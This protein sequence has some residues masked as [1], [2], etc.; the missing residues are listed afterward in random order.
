MWNRAHKVQRIPKQLKH[1]V[2]KGLAVRG[3]S[4]TA[5]HKDCN[6]TISLRQDSHPVVILPSRKKDDSR[7]IYKCPL[8]I[9]LYNRFMGGVDHTNQIRGYYHTPI[10]CCECYKYIFWFLFD[11]AT[12][13]AF[14]LCYEFSSLDIR[15][16]K[17]FRGE[18][19]KEL[20]GNY[21]SKK[22]PGWA[23]ITA[24]TKHFCQNHFPT[25]GSDQIH[26]CH[27]SS[28]YRK[29]SQ[30]MWFCRDCILLLCHRAGLLLS[31]P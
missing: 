20:I 23:S 14:I 3:D 18:L 22:K 28:K 10:K 13:K 1:Y 6:I 30:A 31:V 16:V 9:S 17:T 5:Q 24:T 7:E 11:V 12:T 27:Y 29:E 21:N 19:V 2:K 8:S 25:H 26:H 4:K 15:T